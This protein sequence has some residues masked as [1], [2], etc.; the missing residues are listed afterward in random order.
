MLK[1]CFDYRFIYI[2]L[3]LSFLTTEVSEAIPK[4]ILFG[5]M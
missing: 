3:S 4:G 1:E 2:N 5:Q